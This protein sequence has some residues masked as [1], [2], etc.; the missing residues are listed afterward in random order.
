MDEAFAGLCGYW[1][2]VDDVV[3][4]DSEED[5]HAAHVR[6]FLQKCA[7]CMI[8]LNRDKWEYAKP[9]VTFTGFQLSQDGYSVDTPALIPQITQFPTP[10]SCTDLR[11]FLS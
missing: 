11:A 9:W 6:Q 7:E 10:T 3:I 2:V 1:L 8:T 5:K 4:F